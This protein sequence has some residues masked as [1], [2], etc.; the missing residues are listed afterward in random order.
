MLQKFAR[1]FDNA[2]NITKDS[3]KSYLVT[4]KVLGLSPSLTELANSP[5]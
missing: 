4:Y 1:A 3:Y 5:T 2:Y